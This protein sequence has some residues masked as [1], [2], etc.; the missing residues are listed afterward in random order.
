[1]LPTRRLTPNNVFQLTE[2]AWLS[3]PV[4]NLL[5]QYITVCLRLDDGSF[6]GFRFLELDQHGV[7]HDGDIALGTIDDPSFIEFIKK[8]SKHPAEEELE[9]FSSVCDTYNENKSIKKTAK[10]LSLS[11]ERVRRVLITEGLYT[12]EQYEKI[13]ELLNES[14]TIEEIGVLINMKPKQIKTYLPYNK[15]YD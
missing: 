13:T 8:I 14:K 7:Y 10:L 5:R 3:K 11:E 12:C 6:A 1:M 15:E 2:R 9:L 4:P